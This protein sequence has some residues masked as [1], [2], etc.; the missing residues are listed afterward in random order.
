MMNMKKNISKVCL[1]SLL[2]FMLLFSGCGKVEFIH[3]NNVANT[4]EDGIRDIEDSYTKNMTI[5]EFETQTGLPVRDSLPETYKAAPLSVQA[6]YDNNDNIINL[7]VSIG[8]DNGA[9]TII[10]VYS[11]DLWSDL[12]YSPVGD[13]YGGDTSDLEISKIGLV[14]ALY[15]RY[16]DSSQTQNKIGHD[17]YIAQFGVK[18][19]YVYVDSGSMSQDDFE[20]LT[21]ALIAVGNV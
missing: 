4:G 8:E 21:A 15:Y 14:T 10:S 5:D 16:T 7:T 9:P 19:L 11:T 1:A 6:L 17:A 20:V 13:K 18:N 3:Y 12:G 2:I